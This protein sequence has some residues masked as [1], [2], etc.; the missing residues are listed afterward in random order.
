MTDR[1]YETRKTEVTAKAGD[2]PG[3][4]RVCI[5]GELARQLGHRNV[6][7]DEEQKP[8]VLTEPLP[9]NVRPE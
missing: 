4:E 6:G 8:V 9:A 7:W 2:C 1:N 5:D 3:V